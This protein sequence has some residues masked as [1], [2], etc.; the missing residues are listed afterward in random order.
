[1][2]YKEETKKCQN[3]KK[4][5]IIEPDDFSFYEKIKV[6]PPTF[7]PECRLQRRLA[8]M[9]SLTLFKRDCDLCGENGLSMYE[10]NV[11]FK[12][13]CHKCWW[14]DK[15]DPKSYGKDVDFSK[16][17]LGQWKELLQKTP[18]LGLAIDTTTGNLSPYT[19][20]CSYAKNCYL[21]YYSD[22]IEDSAFGY[23][24]TNSKDIYN[25]GT[26]MD[27]NICY[28]SSHVYKSYN[29]VGAIGNNR[30]CYD[31]FFI[32]DCEGCHNCFGLSSAKNKSYCF[33]GEQL[34]KEEYEEKMKSINLGSCEK[35][36][37]WKNK[38]QDYF[39]TVSPRPVWDTLSNNVSGSYVF[40]SKNCHDS[41]DVIDCEDSRFLM[42]IKEGNVRD[43]Y[44]YT[45]WGNNVSLTYDSVT[46]G[47]FASNVKFSQHC[48]TNIEN[49]EY[50]KLQLGGSNCFGCVSMKKGN[51][52]ILNKQYTKED[53]EKLIQKIKKHMDDMPYV[54]KKGN[55][56]KYGEFFPIEFSP[57]AYN[58]SFNDFFFPLN[59]KEIVSLGLK[60]NKI[61]DREYNITLKNNEIEDNLS[62]VKDSIINEVIKCIACVR[63]FK[64]IHQELQFLR[65]Y[66]LPLPRKCP[67]CRIGD[68]INIWILN[69]KLHNR[70]CGKCKVE[71]KT[72]YSEERAPVIYCKDC[73]KKEYY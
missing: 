49:I 37:A 9:P 45:D 2:E 39:K 22:H 68:K 71:F 3:C 73:Y 35:Y 65:K 58:N 30:S 23:Q 36:F 55:I 18:I 62:N 46:V 56:Y 7:C 70:N 17:F 43:C 34:S 51:Y 64:I 42:L 6:P 24:F 47:E 66:N 33:L 59:E 26:I 28:D 57:H 32:R 10:P 13:Y 20:H 69:M 72:H 11:P 38:C 31:C 25:C 15:W 27:T 44:D 48:S 29:I 52:C 60:W 16:P 67:F 19:N 40:H 50:S 5:F 14:S 41:F 4:D 1:M 12:V 54:D 61:E 63:G 53:Y 21:I 8:W